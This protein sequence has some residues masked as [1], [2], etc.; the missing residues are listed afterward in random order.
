MSQIGYPTDTI[1]AVTY[2]CDARCDMCNIWQLKPQEYLTVDD[3]AKVPSTLRDVNISGG[4]AFMRKDIIDIVKV[5]H[6]KCNGPRIVVSTNGFR[7]EQIITKM[8]EL[9]K[10]I[11][12]IGIGV[13]LDGIGETHNKIRGIKKAY[14]KTLKTLQQL[15]EREF[16]NVRIGFTAM[17]DNADEMKRV[18]DL[19]TSMG[20]EFTMAVAQNSDIYFSTQ[21]NDQVKVGAL[22]D[23]LGY[24][25]KK[26]LLSH[27][28]KRWM[29][30]YYESG[31]LL[32]NE[33]GRRLLECRAGIDFFYLAPEGLVYPCL[34]IP[35][36][37]GDL[38]G[39][40]FEEVWESERAD[41]VRAE[42][43]GCEKCWM[44][45]TARSALRRNLP[46]A[47][48]WIAKEKIKNHLK[49]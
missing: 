13:S 5:I 32:F 39:H 26:E 22:T 16:G 19:A 25:I 27:H 9:R 41:Q 33:E 23:A 11:P 37:M 48:T 44:I 12:K 29:R 15:R 40:T 36:I 6:Q 7:S 45:C 18:Y 4:E 10:W 35:S 17:N 31:S 28:P 2:R 38:K 30:A 3:Y 21:A 20:F 42:I 1:I 47:L 34:T 24:V 46:K 8:E 14:E 49:T 43:K